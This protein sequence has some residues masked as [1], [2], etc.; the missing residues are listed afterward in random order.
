[1]ILLVIS[2][3]PLSLGE[4]ARVRDKHIIV[5]PSSQPSPLREKEI[6]VL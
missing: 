1:L 6:V 3:N 4:R 2:N 5:M